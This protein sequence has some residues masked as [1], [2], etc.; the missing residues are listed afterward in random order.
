MYFYAFLV[1]VLVILAFVFWQ[2][3][4]VEYNFN[5]KY[6]GKDAKG[7]LT[8]V[9]TANS[10]H[11]KFTNAKPDAYYT[12]IIDDPDAPSPKNPDTGTWRHMVV[13]D[14]LGNKLKSMI[15]NIEGA[16]RILTPYAG[17]N[18]PQY[19]G[20]HRY[21]VRLLEQQ[22]VLIT[23]KIPQDRRNWD[24]DSFIT[25]HKLTTVAEKRFTVEKK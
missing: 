5:V 22:A 21:H 16:G 19:S 8:V 14:I 2:W 18:P 24:I 6:G 1:I 9:Q 11:I 4:L 15:K 17:P 10:P 20:P 12:V 13:S 23:P 3:A 7:E 25:D